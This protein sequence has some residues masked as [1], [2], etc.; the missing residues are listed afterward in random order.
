MCVHTR[1]VAPAHK[2]E[3]HSNK[4]LLFY[5]LK[6]VLVEYCEYSV[7][8]IL[9]I[10]NFSARKL[11]H[12]LILNKNHDDNSIKCTITAVILV[13]YFIDKH[14]ATLDNRNSYMC[15]LQNVGIPY[16]ECHGST[17]L[18]VQYNLYN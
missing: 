17:F 7:I 12:P 1:L 16:S 11:W 13:Q 3:G 15:T 2:S 4:A 8:S 5:H 9:V 18:Q 10:L 6:K 14:N